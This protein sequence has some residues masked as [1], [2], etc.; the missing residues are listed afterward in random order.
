M[1]T[2]FIYRP[3]I[4]EGVPCSIRLCSRGGTIERIDYSHSWAVG[5]TARDQAGQATIDRMVIR[6]LLHLSKSPPGG[7]LPMCSVNN[8]RVSRFA[9]LSDA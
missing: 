1:M 3:K 9:V 4:L 2:L 7:T 8:H 6:I 5:A